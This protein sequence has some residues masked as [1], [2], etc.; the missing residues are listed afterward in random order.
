MK[1]TMTLLSIIVILIAGLYCAANLALLPPTYDGSGDDVIALYEDPSGYDVSDPDGAA[2]IIVKTNLEKTRSENV[3][4]SVV[5][6]YRGYDTMGESFVLLT[7]VC[8][9]LVIL[10]KRKAGKE[11]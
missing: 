8:G 9:A 10:R 11:E 3:V 5:F 2:E 6:N 7:A 1:K 4:A